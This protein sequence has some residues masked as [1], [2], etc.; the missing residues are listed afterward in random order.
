LVLSSET[1]KILG[2]NISCT[3]GV[4][5]ERSVSGE[6]VARITIDR[7]PLNKGKYRVGVYLFC[8]KGLH[9]YA[10][11]DP[12]AH[13]HLTHAGHEPGALLLDGLWTNGLPAS[14]GNVP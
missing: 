10:M 7:I 3:Q 1:G 4:V 13:L 14:S 11:V 5:F 8:E 12:V 2:S 9:G 6:G